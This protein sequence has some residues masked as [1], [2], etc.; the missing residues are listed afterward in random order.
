MSGW[1]GRHRG[2]PV[3]YGGLRDGSS[4]AGAGP[5]WIKGTFTRTE[6]VAY[7]LESARCERDEVTSRPAAETDDQPSTSQHGGRKIGKQWFR[8]DDY[9]GIEAAL[10]KL[11]RPVSR[12]IASGAQIQRERFSRPTLNQLEQLKRSRQFTGQGHGSMLGF[13]EEIS[14]L[15]PY[16][17]MG[18]SFEPAEPEPAWRRRRC[19]DCG[20]E[21]GWVC[22]DRLRKNK[23]VG[24]H[25]RHL[26]QEDS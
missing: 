3:I 10:L 6:L 22:R 20:A 2:D 17:P 8:V 23:Q 12:E 25:P 15:D 24:P 4:G 7:L 21:P 5:G 19:P 18:D 11:R 9:I 1:M 14:D 13:A 26:G 16:E